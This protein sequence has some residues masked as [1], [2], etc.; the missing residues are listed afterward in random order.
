MYKI[1]VHYK[2]NIKGVYT[3]EE[4]TA[5]D[6]EQAKQK[7]HRMIDRWFDIICP[8]IDF[9]HYE[10]KVL[11]TERLLS[12]NNGIIFDYNDEL[13]KIKIDLIN[14]TLENMNKYDEFITGEKTI[15]ENKRQFKLTVE[16]I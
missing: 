15:E 16:E 9:Y 1:Q 5:T 4:E 11:H 2:S 6:M 7:Q 10:N 14:Q 3:K 12:T 13:Y 8:H